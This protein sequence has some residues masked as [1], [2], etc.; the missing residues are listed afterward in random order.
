MTSLRA[1]QGEIPIRRPALPDKDHCIQC[2]CFYSTIPRMK[3]GGSFKTKVT[4]RGVSQCASWM[5]S[6]RAQFLR[7]DEGSNK[8]VLEWKWISREVTQSP[9]ERRTIL[10]CQEGNGCQNIVRNPLEQFP[11]PLLGFIYPSCKKPNVASPFLYLLFLVLCFFCFFIVLYFTL[12]NISVDNRLLEKKIQKKLL[13][14]E[15]RCQNMVYNDC[16]TNAEQC[17]H[18]LTLSCTLELIWKC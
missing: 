15:D 6:T 11:C 14:D 17:V 18:H 10:P 12:M 2:W 8:V 9:R 16:F 4:A 5:K 1:R 3:W 7:G 13:T